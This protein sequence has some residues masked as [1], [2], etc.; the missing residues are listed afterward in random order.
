MLIRRWLQAVWSRLF[1]FAF[2]LGLLA[3]V[4][5]AVGSAP[6]VEFNHALH[7]PALFA[8]PPILAGRVTHNGAA[9]AGV[10]LSLWFYN[11]ANWSEISSTT[12]NSAGQYAFAPP[13]S[14]LPGQKYV[15]EFYNESNSSRLYYWDTRE[16]TT[17]EANT[18]A[19][20]G[21]FD[22]ADVA[23]ASPASGS[24]VSMPRTFSWNKRNA[25][26]G[27]SYIYILVDQVAD[28][29]YFETSPLG[30]VSSYQLASRPPGFGTNTWYLWAMQITRVDGA[31]G[32]SYWANYVAFS[33]SAANT[34]D[35]LL[36]PQAELAA[37][38]RQS[39]NSRGP[40]ALMA[41]GAGQK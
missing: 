14:L 39:L 24:V 26:P 19:H 23:L 6:A 3:G 12:T 7:V 13:G 40:L 41:A 10:P 28:L 4:G 11:G 20:M 9:A 32:G 18:F 37:D 36:M 31:Q 17:Y 21:D 16:L 38:L 22:I 35:A 25:A 1:V 8:A 15:V 30:F 5:P 2:V 29:P 34:A 27:D 33:G